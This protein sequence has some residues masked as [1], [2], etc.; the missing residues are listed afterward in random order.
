MKSMFVHLP[1]YDGQAGVAEGKA[2]LDLDLMVK[3]IEIIIK[4]L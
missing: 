4:T 1:Y 2:T 3:A